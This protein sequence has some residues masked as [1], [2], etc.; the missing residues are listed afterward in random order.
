[1]SEPTSFFGKKQKPP[2]FNAILFRK[3]DVTEPKTR[4]LGCSNNQ[5]NYFTLSKTI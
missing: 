4:M 1:M 3:N 2:N 5:L